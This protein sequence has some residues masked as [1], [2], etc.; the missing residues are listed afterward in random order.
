MDK[1]LHIITQQLENARSSEEIFGDLPYPDTEKP[2]ILKKKYYQMAKIAHPDAYQETGDKETAKLAFQRLTEWYEK[3][4]AKVSAGV[5]G[6]TY[7]EF[8][9][10]FG[11]LQTPKHTYV[12]DHGYQEGPVYTTYAGK[13]QHNGHT[14]P[15]TLKVTRCAVDNDLAEN[16]AKVL[17]ALRVGKSSRKFLPYVPRLTDSFFYQESRA[18]ES[19]Q[20]NVFERQTGWYSLAE[21]IRAHAGG[22]NPKD[23]AWMWR[24][25]L[26]VL[27]FAHINGVIH[28]AVLPE[29]VWIQPD[30]HGLML[31]EWSFAV[32]EPEPGTYIQAMH[33]GYEAWYPREVR[34]KEP[35]LPGTDI[36][37]AARCMIALLAGDPVTANPPAGVPAPLGN[38]FKGCCLPGL[39][40]RPQDAWALK[41]E[42]DA[43]IEGLWGRREFRPFSM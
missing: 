9:H 8:E 11:L 26:V 19:R 23:M 30:D 14:S 28:G 32:R 24:R 39:K 1:E 25:L 35:P 16:E 7:G 10:W 34:R 29:N 20:V 4:T 38:F 18:A 27:G 41:S 43:L 12:L 36:D 13:L 17:A 42:F 5:Y 33:P 40:S 31:A 15:V 6:E 2:A 22:V 21:V 37:M 3:A